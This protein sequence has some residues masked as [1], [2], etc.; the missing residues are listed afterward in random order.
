MYAPQTEPPVSGH[1]A[2][3]QPGHVSLD[4]RAAGLVSASAIEAET[5]EAKR[6]PRGQKPR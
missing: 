6:G 5:D 3:H 4:V 1:L 2:D